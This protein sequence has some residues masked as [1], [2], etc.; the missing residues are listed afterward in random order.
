MVIDTDTP[1]NPNRTVYVI[2]TLAQEAIIAR[3][4]KQEGYLIKATMLGDGKDQYISVFGV[5]KIAPMTEAEA[6]EAVKGNRLLRP[7]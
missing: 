3:A 1:T 2:F 7:K 5:Y 4:W 6:I